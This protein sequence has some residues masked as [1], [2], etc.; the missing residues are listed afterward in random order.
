MS[1]EKFLSEE[2][3]LLHRGYLEGLSARY[4]VM[5]KCYPYIK[6]K[7]LC[8]LARIRNGRLGEDKKGILRLKAEITCHKIY[9]SSFGDKYQ[10]S[11]TVKEKY[12]SEASFL[13]ELYNKCIFSDAKFCVL[14]IDRGNIYTEEI[15]DY[16]DILHLA[17]PL[18]AI[19]L[20][21]HAYFED[22]KFDRNA[23]IENA[24]SRINI[25]YFDNNGI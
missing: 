9:F 10:T 6:G 19:D 15:F 4:S 12:K 18:L 11:P 2:S 23:Y 21:E 16:I 13:Y 8:E 5:E 25:K 17:R 7:E 22:Y 24:V 1:M 3:L 20:C 14:G